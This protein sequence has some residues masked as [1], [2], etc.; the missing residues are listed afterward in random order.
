VTSA[1]DQTPDFLVVGSGLAGL[2]FGALMARAG[3]RVR[4]LEA[5]HHPG[6]Y[7]HTFAFG[8]DGK[9]YRFNAQF[10]T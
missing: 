1:S 4:V 2:A 5:H 7:G 10:H 9:H 8:N 6:G 3:R